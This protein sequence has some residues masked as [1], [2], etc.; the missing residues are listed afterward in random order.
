MKE[1]EGGRTRALFHTSFSHKQDQLSSLLPTPWCRKPSMLPTLGPLKLGGE[2]FLPGSGRRLAL[3]VQVPIR[4]QRALSFHSLSCTYNELYTS[5]IFVNDYSVACGEHRLSSAILTVQ[6][7]PLPKSSAGTNYLPAE[8]LC[9][10]ISCC[11]LLS[12]CLSNLPATDEIKQVLA[13]S[14]G[15]WTMLFPLPLGIEHVY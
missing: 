7:K 5:S 10:K 13:C 4:I 8:H 6:K 3:K 15:L 14:A 12:N 11:F 9:M 1:E 2:P